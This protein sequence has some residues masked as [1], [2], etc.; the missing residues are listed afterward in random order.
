MDDP[1]SKIDGQPD[2]W[3]KEQ[4]ETMRED[5]KMDVMRL[6]PQPRFPG[7][8]DPREAALRH[9][10]IRERNIQRIEKSQAGY[11]RAIK[12]GFKQTR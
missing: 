7:M 11:S 12:R 6:A 10:R 4:L 5:R 8:P 9:I 2:V 1:K 3:T